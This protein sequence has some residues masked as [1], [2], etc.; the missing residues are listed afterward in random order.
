MRLAIRRE[1]QR[2]SLDQLKRT[3]CD[4]QAGAIA[5]HNDPGFWQR[6]IPPILFGDDKFLGGRIELFQLAMGHILR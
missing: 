4:A 3:V 2:Q 5:Q 1:M 6:A